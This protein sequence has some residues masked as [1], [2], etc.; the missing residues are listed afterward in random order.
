MKAKG[1]VGI[2]GSGDVG[3]TLAA[4]LSRHGYAVKIGSR[5]PQK[6]SEFASKTKGVTAGSFADVATFGD[7]VI[8]ATLGAAA[9][10][11]VGLAGPSS[12]EG[13]LVLD[14]TNALECFN[15]V[16]HVQMVDPKFA[17]GTPPMLICGNDA[18]AKKR[19]EALRRD[20]GWP[21][22]LDVGGLDGARWLE[23]MVPLWVRA[24]VSMGLTSWTHAFKVVR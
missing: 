21:G 7:S 9:E 12:L 6:L 10:E 11:A 22:V 2:L 24:A 13:K 20:L 5:T 23:A 16:P 8:V 19:T 4:G 3:R 1:K 17:E 15:T 14:A 18:D